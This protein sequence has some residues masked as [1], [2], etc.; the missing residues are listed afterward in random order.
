MISN[1]GMPEF[2]ENRVVEDVLYEQKHGNLFILFNV[3]FPTFIE[4]NKKEEILKILE[5]CDY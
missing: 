2:D 5:S 4:S 3:T 1:E